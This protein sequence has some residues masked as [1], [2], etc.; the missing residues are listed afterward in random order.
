MEQYKTEILEVEKAFAKLAKEEG[1]KTAFLT[2]ASDEAV[3]HR[4]NKIVSGKK[5]IEEYFDRQKLKNVRLDW[6]PDFISV[7]ASGDLAYTYGAYTFEGTD[8]EG[9][10]IKFSGIFHTVWTREPSGEWRYVWD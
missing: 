8:E 3:L 4:E 2:Y 10:E 7:A 9:R 1:M 5:A 6:M